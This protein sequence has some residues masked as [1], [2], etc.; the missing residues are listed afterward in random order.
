MQKIMIRNKNDYNKFVAFEKTLYKQRRRLLFSPTVSEK[1]MIWKYLCLL[2]IC[3]YYFNTHKKIRYYFFAYL[4][5]LMRIKTGFSIPLNV[6]DMGLKVNHL[7]IIHLSA[8]H[9][10]K[11]V[12]IAGSCSAIKN[13]LKEGS[14]VIGDGCFLGINSIFIGPIKVP[15]GCLIGAG[16]LLTKTFANENMIIA[17]SPA[18]EITRLPDNY[19]FI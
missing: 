11:N 13:G 19:K 8:E 5:N 14:P 7:G 4:K 6:C 18:K 1:K 15:N 17:G 10:G 2:R 12:I 3:E 16:A 9:V